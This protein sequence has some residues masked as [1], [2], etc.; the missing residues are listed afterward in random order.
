MQQIQSLMERRLQI[1]FIRSP[2]IPIL[3]DG[4]AAIKIYS[5]PLAVF[6]R[7]D[8]PLAV[9]HRFQALPLKQ[10]ATEPFVFFPRDSGTSLYDQVVS[11]CR[12][13]GFTPRIEQEA[14][15]NATILGLVA[16]G[17]GVSILPASL[18][19]SGVANVTNC[20]LT[21]AGP[22]TSM[23]LIYRRHDQSPASAR[24]VALATGSQGG[25]AMP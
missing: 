23:W 17:L 12:R 8:H 4:I 11:L 2:T 10:L 25:R 15:E 21:P 19:S 13:V 16:A 24:F 6:M 20:K 7:V 9:S 22:P 1:G 18:R 3:P 5:E 14:R